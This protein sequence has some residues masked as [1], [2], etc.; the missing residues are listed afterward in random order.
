[1]KRHIPSWFGLAAGLLINA[2]TVFAQPGN[3][4]VVKNQ[5]GAPGEQNVVVRV[6]VKNVDPASGIQFT[7]RDLSPHL[8]PIEVRPG[9]RLLGTTFVNYDSTTQQEKINFFILSPDSVRVVVISLSGDSLQ[10]G[11]GDFVEVLYNVKSNAPIGPIALTLTDIVA[12]DPSGNVLEGSSQDGVFTVGSP[13]VATDDATTI[14][15]DA[16]AVSIPVLLN[17]TGDGRLVIEGLSNPKHGTVKLNADSTAVLYT[18]D[19]DFNGE[20]SFSYVV[21]NGLGSDTGQVTVTVTPVNDAPEITAPQQAQTDED[22]QLTFS[23]DTEN[24]IRIDD[25]EATE[26]NDVEV[27][28]TLQATSTVKLAD[29]QG[30]TLLGETTNNSDFVKFTGTLSEVNDALDGLIYTPT[31]DANGPTAGR[32]SIS[33]KDLDAGDY[34]EIVIAIN[35]VN[36]APVITT[37]ELPD[38]TE[39]VGWTAQIKAPDI[40][41]DRLTFELEGDHPEWLAIDPENGVLRG[42]PGPA[43]VGIDTFT[44]TVTDDP[45]DDDD[46]DGLSTSKEFTIEVNPDATPPSFTLTPE[47]QA[48]T[49]T[50]ATIE[51]ESSEPT[52]GLIILSSAARTDTVRVN[53]L[54]KEGHAELLE[55]TPN[56]AYTATVTITD[57]RGNFTTSDIIEFSTLAAPD[58]IAPVFIEGPVLQAR[59][60]NS[61]T[62]AW[63]A[64][65]PAQ[66]TLRL[67]RKDGVLTNNEQIVLSTT[68]FNDDDVLTASELDANAVYIG[69]LE[70]V[71]QTGNGPT[72]IATDNNP[73]PVNG[74]TLALPD[75]LKPIL[76][77]GPTVE[78]I[79]DI[80]SSVLYE[81]N[82]AATTVVE[83]GKTEALGL[84]YTDDRFVTEHDAQLFSLEPATVYFFRIGGKDP[85]DNEMDFSDIFTFRTKATPDVTAPVFTS[86]PAVLS[87]TDQTAIISWATSEMAHFRIK[88]AE[89]GSADTLRIAKSDLALEQT[90]TLIDLTPETNYFFS[91]RAVDGS[92]NI[93]PAQTVKFLTKATPDVTAPRLIGRVNVVSRDH[94]RLTV[95]WETNEPSGSGGETG[96]TRTANE[97]EATEFS[98]DT[99]P[100]TDH[101]ATFTN[102]D[103]ATLYYFRVRS[104]D[105]SGNTFESII[106][107]ARTRAT[108]D[109]TPPS[110]SS[111]FASN[112]LNSA[113]IEWQ[114]SERAD[115]RVVYGTDSTAV[116]NGN[117]SVAD[118]K[119]D[120]ERVTFHTITLT[121]LTSGT[122]YFYRVQSTDEAGNVSTLEPRSPRSPRLFT[123]QQAAD[124]TPPTITQISETTGS[125]TA[126]IR[127]RTNEPANSVVL[128]DTNP[129]TS[130]A[131]LINTKQEGDRVTEHE[132]TLEDLTPN[133]AYR[134][135]VESTDAAGLTRRAPTGG[136]AR[137]FR[138]DPE[139]VDDEVPLFTQD[140]FLGYASDDKVILQWETDEDADERVFY[141]KTGAE[142]YDEQ[143]GDSKFKTFHKV[144]IAGLERGIDYEFVASSADEAGNQAFAPN[145]EVRTTKVIVTR[146]GTKFKITGIAQATSGRFTTLLAPDTQAPVI[147]SGPT[148]TST[149][150]TSLTLNWT[151]DELSTSGVKFGVGNTNQQ[152][153]SGTLVTNHAMTLTNLSPSTVYSFVVSSTDPNNNGPSTSVQ[154]VAQTSAQADISPP[155]ISNVNVSSVF[156]NSTDGTTATITW[157]T[158]EGADTKVDY[159]TTSALGQTK[160]VN[161]TVIN[162][163]VTITRLTPGQSYSYRVS[164]IDASNNGPSLSS[165]ASFTAA[166]NPD[167]QPPTFSN[168][169]SSGTSHNLIQVTWTTNENATSIMVVKKSPTDSVTVIN[170]VKGTSHSL[171]V[172]DTL[173]VRPSTSYT[174]YVEGID[175][176]NNLGKDIVRNVTTDA[177][178]DV[179]PPA[180][181]ATLTA[182]AGNEQAQLSWSAVSD[183][184]LKG[185]NVF[186]GSTQIA[187]NLTGTSFTATGLTNGNPYSFT[188]NAVDEANNVSA[189]SPTAQTTPSAGQAPSAPTAAGTFIGGAAVDTVS[190]K[191]ILIVGNSTRVSGRP[192]PT[193]QFAV[194]SDAGLTNLVLSTV[195]VVEG[196]TTNPTHWQVADI[197]QPGGIV[198]LDGTRYHW[199]ARA[200]DTVSDGEWTATKTFITSSGKP[201]GIQLAGMAAGSDRGVVS[202]TWRTFDR[203]GLEGFRVYRSLNALGPYELITAR[204]IG[205]NESGEYRFVDGNV[206]ANSTYYYQIEAINTDEAPQ[207]FGPVSVKV[208]PPNVF[209]LGQNF[210]N[211]FNPETSIRYELPTPGQVKLV[212]YNLLGQEVV[213][214]VEAHQGAGFHTVRWNGL[215]TSKQQVA[216]GVYFYR[217]TVQ[218]G[219]NMVFFNARKML[220][221]K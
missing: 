201:T 221:I 35:P 138:T 135:L 134:Y 165:I 187:S 154:A 153:E 25:V 40:D 126:T 173:F 81:T 179:T 33:V 158:N 46:D 175:A 83:Y 20:D 71:D 23:S 97:I 94:N 51:W 104:P 38:A 99:N 60:D 207:R 4:I 70:L 170:G 32:L 191:P 29:L 30:I 24:E 108:P 65:E 107:S 115:S 193:Y 53:T 180:A 63:K 22:T 113:I 103:A 136:A 61:L 164:S 1:M 31:K 156:V 11:Q 89:T 92:N 66:A 117:T 37:E 76:F 58:G 194:Y 127:W 16:T 190:L 2:A 79:T 43:D 100:T 199:R 160:T 152:S 186:T 69:T 50:R 185:Y 36:D 77:S 27:E 141:R 41:N 87:T 10:P 128:F 42:T 49:D 48:R 93:S 137:A 188:V 167:T 86:G 202:V 192:V 218:D 172:T 211:P 181:P 7:L 118:E 147:L 129:K 183:E 195:G 142:L 82:E 217:I 184:G 52:T 146:V 140:P 133:T 130:T 80:H 132:I 106:D 15:E 91:V 161:E 149:S 131:P 5:T 109:E 73:S 148:I 96:K 26:D 212:V 214:L 124:T 123:T 14:T 17:D 74:K 8:T 209:T 57:A 151:T 219:N 3:S 55:L 215:N 98:S 178:P 120:G 125:R 111:I 101:Q 78:G 208:S 112:G 177:G 163:S 220:L 196:T 75:T 122:R 68:S 12:S 84:S 145:V 121:E 205:V 119:R 216:S 116:A 198:L 105:A 155:V 90:V 9:S 169:S 204:Q 54:S 176:S 168:V 95:A 34:H 47:V 171:A 174:Y 18:P 62:F 213:T 45:S 162:H 203:V 56:T 44:V 143:V 13:L 157:T 206:L 139:V 67:T 150:T 102:L 159:G 28:V 166:S 39:G 114:T 144:T 59:T 189:G 182:K 19:E 200:N 21:S 64:S 72:K 197:S 110:I 88:Y 6:Q 85:S 210:P